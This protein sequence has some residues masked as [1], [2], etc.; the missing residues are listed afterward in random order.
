MRLKLLELK[1][2]GPFTEQILI[3]DSSTPG[4]HI[5]YGDNEAGKSSALR[6]L[7]ALLYGFHS[8]TPDNFVHPYDQL[9]VSGC[10]ERDDGREL[11]F[12]RRKRRIGDL[13]DGDGNPLEAATLD[14]FLQGVEP[15]FFESLYGIDHRQLVEGGI[16]ILSQKGE[17]GQ[18]LFA[19]GAGLSSLKKV[20]DKFEQEA[21]DL[22]KPTGQLPLINKAVKRFKELKKEVGEASLSSKDWRDLKDALNEAKF[23]RSTLEK[24]RDEK[25]SMLRRLERLEQAIPELATLHVERERLRELGEVTLLP[26][27]F[28]ERYRLLDEL[29][30]ESKNQLQKTSEKLGQLEEKRRSI[31]LNVTLLDHGELVDD[32]HQRLGEYRKGQKDKPER[33]G[34]RISLRQEAAQ[35]MKQVRPDLGL[36]DVDSLRPVL[37]RKKTIQTLS[38][39]FEAI[40]HQLRQAENQ[41][42]IA[43]LEMR[44]VKQTLA[45]LE[46]I[47]NSQELEQ[48]VRL[49]HRTGDLDT[50][51]V[52]HRDRV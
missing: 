30:R 38:G 29:I 31:S 48:A 44:E 40:N 15:E 21:A 13:L 51:I 23:R 47:Q 9:L 37:A 3:F 41:S 33:N 50:L 2:F 36:E 43:E 14:P 19:A 45:G 8:Q 18:T 42:E 32:F 34:M 10:L 7:K 16:E 20:V 46:E 52:E 5:I 24:E 35:L 49:A 39:R 11:C 26:S 17:V 4:L 25:N 12:Q 27:D 1:A 6:G 28:S 22:F